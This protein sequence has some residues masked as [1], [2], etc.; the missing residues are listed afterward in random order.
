MKRIVTFLIVLLVSTFILAGCTEK[1]VEAGETLVVYCWND[2]FQQRFRAYYNST[3]T[4]PD[5]TKIKWVI[6]E[7]KNNA[8]QQKLDADL[9]LQEDAKADEKIDIFL[10]E[11]DYALK[12]VESDYALDV[13][14]DIGL[15][16][17]DMANQY[18]YTQEIVTDSNGK[19]RGTTWQATPGLFAYRRSIAT[20]VLGTDDPVEVQKQLADWTKFDAAAAKMK[21]KDYFMLS[22]YD[23]SYRTFSNNMSNPWVNDK[24]EIVIDPSLDK[25]VTQTK[26]YT[27]NKY[28]EKSSLWDAVWSGGQGP[29]GK[30]FGYF[31]STWGINFTL[32]GNSLADADKPAEVGNGIYGD[33]AVC[34]GPESYYWGG[35]WICAAKGTDNVDLIKDIMLKLTCDKNTMKLIT[36]DTQ[37][38]TNNKVS[39]NEIANNVDYGSDFL[40][41]QNHVA[42]FVKSADKIDMKNISP[43]DQG[44]NE[45][46][47]EAF[48]AYFDGISTKDQA[49]A[50]FYSKIKVLYPELKK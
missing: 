10:V 41:G 11:A 45:K 7:N 22:G 33:W 34:E 35:T 29:E 37:D 3:D 13:M 28:N 46:Y 19:I 49:L 15:T 23:D 40:G 14:G 8:Y 6:T 44:L 32:K 43:Y 16:A 2:E 12:Y 9:L 26:T 17:A 42:L 31:Y 5:G 47:Q 27:D 24:S 30:V 39:M 1:E 38:F 18:K 4:L 36:L 20:E 21:A 25:W 48:K 50:D